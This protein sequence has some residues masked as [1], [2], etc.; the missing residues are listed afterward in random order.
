MVSPST[1][2]IYYLQLVFCTGSSSF[3]QETTVI[4]VTSLLFVLFLVI[5]VVL[6]AFCWF[7][8]NRRRFKNISEGFDIV[9]LVKNNVYY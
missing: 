2:N 6:V 1:G 3:A 7:T 5:G 8:I 9:R 4:I